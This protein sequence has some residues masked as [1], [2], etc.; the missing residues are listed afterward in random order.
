M[1]AEGPCSVAKKTGEASWLPVDDEIDVALPVLQ[2]LLGSMFRDGGETH[3]LE[4]GFQQLGMGRGEF[5][6]LESAKAHGVVEQV[7][8]LLLR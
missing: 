8:P 7:S 4:E 2:D 3:L 6:E 5:D 1:Q